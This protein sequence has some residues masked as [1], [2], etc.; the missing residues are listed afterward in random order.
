[1]VCLS[2]YLVHFLLIVS[3]GDGVSFYVLVHFLL[4]VNQGDGVSFYVPCA[5][6]TYSGPR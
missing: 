5:L 3:Q 6:P 4:I 2:M 1:M